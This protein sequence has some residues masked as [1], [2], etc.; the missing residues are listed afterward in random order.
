[1]FESGIGENELGEPGGTFELTMPEW[2]APDTDARTWFLDDDGSLTVDE[3]TDD[4][5]DVY[6]HDPDAGAT[7]FLAGSEGGVDYPLFERL[8]AFDWTRFPE[9]RSLNYLTEPFDDDALLAGPGAVTLHFGSEA[10]DAAVQ[11]TLTEVRPDGVEVLLTSGLLRLSA[12]A[13][14]EATTDG[15]EIGRTFAAEDDEPLP[16]GELVEG[17]DPAALGRRTRRGRAHALKIQIGTPGRN[18]ATWT[19]ESLHPDGEIPDPSGGPWSP[20]ALVGDLHLPADVAGPDVVAPA[21]RRRPGLPRVRGGDQPQRG[22]SCAGPEVEI[23]NVRLTPSRRRSASSTRAFGSPRS[24]P[25]PARSSAP[26][27]PEAGHGPEASSPGNYT[28]PSCR[29][30]AVPSLPVLARVERLDEEHYLV[31]GRA[32]TAADLRLAGSPARIR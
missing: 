5:V 4:G 8:W 19:F 21:P 32:G 28:I 6:D 26:V 30:S 16:D 15:L 10:D 12:R 1:M 31:P 7:T 23:F 13:E 14:D 25:L 11:V 9:G 18:H 22:V 3:P 24:C 29:G 2:P 17:A 27:I 20:H